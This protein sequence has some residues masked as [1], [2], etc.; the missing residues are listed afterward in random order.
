MSYFLPRECPKCE[1]IVSPHT[2]PRVG[3]LSICPMCNAV[4]VFTKGLLVRL[5]TP[6]ER[7]YAQVTTTESE[8]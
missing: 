2:R 4:M 3:D 1:R 7:A 6:S 8:A 5:A